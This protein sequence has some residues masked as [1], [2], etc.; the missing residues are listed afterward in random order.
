M[1][2]LKTL[3]TPKESTGLL[4]CPIEEDTSLG[5]STWK[6]VKITAGALAEPLGTNR[7]AIINAIF[8][9]VAIAPFFSHATRAGITNFAAASNLRTHLSATA[10]APF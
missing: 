3:P 6:K 4:L 1:R 10:L 8:K 2:F 9:P 5:T 7:S